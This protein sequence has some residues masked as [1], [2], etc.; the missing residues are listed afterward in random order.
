MVIREKMS[1]GNWTMKQMVDA[2]KKRG[3]TVTQTTVQR[4][5]DGGRPKDQKVG[6]AVADILRLNDTELADWFTGRKVLA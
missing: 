3:F 2:L 6:L 5:R 1:A 4:W